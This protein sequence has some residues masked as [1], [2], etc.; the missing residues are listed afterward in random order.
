MASPAGAAGAVRV[1]APTP[2]Q[3]RRMRLE[4]SERPRSYSTGQELEPS[5]QGGNADLTLAETVTSAVSTRPP[6]LKEKAAWVAD[7]AR[8][9][10]YCCGQQFTRTLRRHHCRF[11]GEV[12]CARCSAHRVQHARI[13]I[14]CYH[15][16]QTKQLDKVPNTG[17][18]GEEFPKIEGMLSKWTNQMYGWQPRYFVIEKGAMSCFLGTKDKMG[19]CRASVHLGQCVVRTSRVQPR[20]FEVYDPI[21]DTTTLCKAPDEH[22]RN[23]WVNAVLRSRV[24]LPCDGTHARTSVGTPARTS[25]DDAEMMKKSHSRSASLVSTSSLKLVDFVNERPHTFQDGREILSLPASPARMG[26]SSS[27]RAT[28]S[29]LSAVGGL[30]APEDAVPSEDVLAAER[31]KHTAEI[32]WLFKSRLT[33]GRDFLSLV[34]EQTRRLIEYWTVVDTG[35]DPV[36]CT[37]VRKDA[38]LFKSTVAGATEAFSD[39]VDGAASVEADCAKRMQELTLALHAAEARATKAEQQLMDMQNDEQPFHREE[40]VSTEQEGVSTEQDDHGFEVLEGPECELDDDE[41]FDAVE[42]GLE[43]ME[44]ENAAQKNINM[45]RARASSSAALADAPSMG[46]SGERAKYQAIV[47]TKVAE[48]LEL[49]DNSDVSAWQPVHKH[50]GMTVSRTEI[51]DAA[52]E[53]IDRTRVAAK[54]RGATAKEVCEFFHSPD[55]K[56]AFDSTLDT[57]NVIADVDA[58]SKIVHMTHKRVWPTAPRDSCTVS[59]IAELPDGRWLVFTLSVEHPKAPIGKCVRSFVFIC[60]VAKSSGTSRADMRC[61]VTYLATVDPGGWAP[62]S[63]VLAVSKREFPKILSKLDVCVREACKNKP[64]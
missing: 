20:R 29:R 31:E 57:I 2:P 12:V 17:Q 63:V 25:V 9:A 33:D 47:K 1:P 56:F 51:V 19:I 21:S 16:Q 53:V 22:S 26:R 55:G 58:S 41:F 39:L 49:L 36:V 38:L 52:G 24:H 4:G 30:V 11:C 54:F 48:A 8:V 50:E 6:Q 18:R 34:K 27:T 32:K 60:L 64:I 43:K 62:R 35:D 40:R 5:R 46:P 37:A 59:H 14:L 45:R 61:D 23:A 15:S 3:I 42:T 10:C 28:S 13:C 7:A 44:K